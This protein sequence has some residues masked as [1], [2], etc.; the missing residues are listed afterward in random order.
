VEHDHRVRIHRGTDRRQRFGVV[1]CT[2]RDRARL[3][4]KLRMQTLEFGLHTRCPARSDGR[5]QSTN[6]RSGFSVL[7]AAQQPGL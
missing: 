7:A 3:G 6:L 5:G 1:Q 2:Q 4:K